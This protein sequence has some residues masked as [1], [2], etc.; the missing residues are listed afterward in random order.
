[1]LC[2]ELCLRAK[3]TTVRYFADILSIFAEIGNQKIPDNTDGISLKD[4][5]LKRRT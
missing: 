4:V 1:M 5:F 2:P 3:Q